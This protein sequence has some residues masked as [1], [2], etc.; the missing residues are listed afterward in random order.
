MQWGVIHA[1]PCKVV[2][3]VAVVP[4]VGMV[5]RHVDGVS[6]DGHRS[7]KIHLLPSGGGLTAEGSRCQAL[8]GTGPQ[9]ANMRPGV[10]AP[11]VEA[12]AGDGASHVSLELDSQ[13][14]RAVWT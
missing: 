14:H 2:L 10:A 11:L 8:T 1:L 7:G 3:V 5:R 13:L 4:R 12:D 9:V 6:G